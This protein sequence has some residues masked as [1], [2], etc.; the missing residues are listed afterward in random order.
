MRTTPLLFW[1]ACWPVFA[2]AAPTQNLMPLP[3]YGRTYSAAAVTRGFYFQ[4]PRNF[5]IVG[6][7]AP[8]EKNVL[9]Q[10]VAVYVM[11]SP[12]PAWPATGSGGLRYYGGFLA[13]GKVISCNVPVTKNDWVGILGAC[14]D[15]SIVHNSYAAT[16]GA[17]PSQV[18]GFPVTLRAFGTQTNV[19]ADQGQGPY[20]AD[21]S[22]PISR[23]EVYLTV[24]AP[25]LAATGSGRRGTV[26]TF[27]LAALSDTGLPY[28]M[29]SSLGT[30]PIPIG[31]R[32]LGLSPGPLMQLSATGV[33][34]TIFQN[35]A[36]LLNAQ[37][38]A[39]ARLAIPNSTFLRKLRIH[40]A[41]VT[42]LPGAPQGVASISGTHMF[43]IL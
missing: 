25:G 37:G 14:G 20:Y 2:L 32:S 4:A 17:F 42:L 31:S 40:T 28:H 24:A 1:L 12:P 10:G 43:T 21:D 6:L 16:P 33:L 18:A 11:T 23:V 30:G 19:M 8:N 39:T 27:T 26:L 3:G 15:S 29:A 5:T 9:Q 38:V 7:R 34:P 36:G 41:F 13:A 35:Y 22:G